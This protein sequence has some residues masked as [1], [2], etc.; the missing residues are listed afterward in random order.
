MAV[1]Y[2]RNIKIPP[3]REPDVIHHANLGSMDGNVFTIIGNRMKNR[4]ACWSVK[5]GNNLAAL[6]C[7]HYT[8]AHFNSKP[9]SEQD[10]VF[11]HVLSA[12]KV[13]E[14]EGKGYEFSRNI[15]LPQ[16]LKWLKRL[17]AYEPLS[18]LSI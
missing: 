5:G 12:A 16:N 18:D 15:S 8:N 11:S 2:D 14:T 17:S 7:R 9:V 6:L 10:N 1:Y 3:T 13:P 4:R